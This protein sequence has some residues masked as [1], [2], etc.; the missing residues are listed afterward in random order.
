MTITACAETIIDQIGGIGALRMMLGPKAIVCDNEAI[1][2][3][4]K[5]FRKANKCRITYV[6]GLDLYRIEFFKYSAR[7]FTCDLIKEFSQ[8][9]A[10]QLRP[11][12]EETT[13]LY[14]RF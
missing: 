5:G 1:T 12:F 13:G 8:V 6:A 3:D 7:K 10:D 9:Y 4:F 11:L 2:F 14:L